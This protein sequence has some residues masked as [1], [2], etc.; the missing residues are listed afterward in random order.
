MQ[1]ITRWF[2]KN[3]NVNTSFPL[4]KWYWDGLS[5]PNW[6][7]GWTNWVP[8]WPT[9]SFGLYVC[10]RDSTPAS[11]KSIC[12]GNVSGR[13]TTMN[14]NSQR[15]SEGCKSR[16]KIRVSIKW[17]CSYINN[18]W[19]GESRRVNIFDVEIIPPWTLPILKWRAIAVDTHPIFF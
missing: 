11:I 13:Y 5:S 10:T 15:K 6:V 7:L 8:Q 1:I 16:N 9:L 12:E 17:G 2:T 4:P 14:N 3:T 18:F 19:T